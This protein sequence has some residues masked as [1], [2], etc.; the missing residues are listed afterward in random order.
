MDVSKNRV[1]SPQIIR[2]NRVFLYFHHPFWGTTNLGNPHMVTYMNHF[3]A[4]GIFHGYEIDGNPSFQ[5]LVLRLSDVSSVKTKHLS[6]QAPTLGL[7][8]RF[9]GAGYV[10]FFWGGKQV[11]GLEIVVGYWDT[12]MFFFVFVLGIK[13][14]LLIFV[15]LRFDFGHGLYWFTYFYISNQPP[16]K[17]PCQAGWV[18]SGG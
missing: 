10:F 15:C 2:F 5:E 3:F 12:A 14:P 13:L 4:N 7:P 16:K 9:L 8:V 6:L 1:F 17:T 18:V 11:T